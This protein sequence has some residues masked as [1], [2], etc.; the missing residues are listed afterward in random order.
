MKTQ[1]EEQRS[2]EAPTTPPEVAE[3]PRKIIGRFVESRN[4]DPG[5]Q[6]PPV[7]LFCHEPPDSYIGGHVARM[8]PMLARNGRAVHLFSR[9]PFTFSEKSVHVHAVGTCDDPDVVAQAKEYTRRASNAFM[10]VLPAGKEVS[11]LAYEWTAAGALGLLHGLRNL[12]GV[13]SLHTL[14]RQRSDATS[15]IARQIS[16][17]EREGL[18]AARSILIHDP[19]TSEAARTVVPACADRLVQARSLF[20]IEA[21]E[22]QLDPGA[23]KARHQVGPIDPVLL[24]IGD[25]DDQYGPDALLRAMPAILRHHTQARLILVGDGQ[26]QWPLRVYARYL[27]LEYAVRL[28]GHIQ[29]RPLFD[30]V[31]AADVV[32]VPS[33]VATP[34][35]PIQAAWAARRPVVATHEAAKGLLEHEKD[36]VLVYPSENSIVWGVERV[37]YDA[38]LRQAIGA[39]GRAKLEERFGWSAL[40]E[41]VEEVLDGV[42]AY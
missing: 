39:A 22:T 27:L 5:A 12:R 16:D 10:D 38:D 28:V 17:I 26:L 14:E 7:A 19:A 4:G 9:H 34:W 1:T 21:F 29:D 37:L 18:E 20:P 23:I 2:T 15:E 25:L 8:V 32:V 31:Q 36:S 40:A 33:R 3:R 41:Q 24:F 6:K 30:L 35:W 11:V 42:P 13:L